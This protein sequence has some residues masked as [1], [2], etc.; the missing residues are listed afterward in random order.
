LEGATA[1]PHRNLDSDTSQTNPTWVKSA[2]VLLASSN[3]QGQTICEEPEK[4]SSRPM[5]QV[6]IAGVT[7]SVNKTLNV[8]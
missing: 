3:F 5:P 2:Q 8:S 1:I 4:Y 6:S 7:F